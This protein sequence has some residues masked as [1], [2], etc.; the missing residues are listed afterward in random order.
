VF[1]IYYTFFAAFSLSVL[2]ISAD[3]F[4][5]MSLPST[6]AEQP[7]ILFISVDDLRPD[8]G[9]YG[10]P[11]ATTP[12]FDGFAETALLFEKAYTQQAVCGP[13]RAALLTGLRPSTTGIKRLDQTVTGTLPDTTTLNSMFKKSGYETVSVGKIYHHFDDDIN[14]WSK[15]PFDSIYNFRKDRKKRGLPKGPP[16]AVWLS[17]ELLPDAKNVAHAV[18]EL[19]RLSKQDNPFFLAVGL[20]RPHLPFR[21]PKK[22][23]DKYDPKSVP[24]PKTTKQQLGAPDWAVVAWEI[25]NYDNLPPKPGPMPKAEGDQLRHGYL[26]A[27]SFVDGLVGQ[28]LDKLS[29]LDLD[30]NTVVVVWGDHG[31]KL[32]DHGGWSKHSNVELD[33]H[34]PLMIRV[35][36][37]KASG[38]RTKALVETVDIYPTLMDVA[39][40]DQPHEL[41]GISL[42]PLT[43]EPD[44]GWKEAV[45]AQFPRYAKHQALMGETVRTDRYRYT[46]WVGVRSGKIIAQELYDHKIDPIESVNLVGNSDYIN[47]LKY[48][49][50][51][52]IMGWKNIHNEMNKKISKNL[53]N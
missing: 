37:M 2:L 40:L 26:A 9:S 47:D 42:L 50:K 34:I 18:N 15:A 45:F 27:I 16:Y 19:D 20:H 35:P 23:W 21:A 11:V 10:H 22:Y 53:I 48:H 8:L 41:E 52:R 49:E 13:S 32:G 46:A 31:F 7:N 4:S 24:A 30:K 33:I 44:Q 43:N 6:S 14:G 12:R 3:A 1:R 51:L 25:W 36:G 29:A 38:E 17:D 39:G 28:L 5:A